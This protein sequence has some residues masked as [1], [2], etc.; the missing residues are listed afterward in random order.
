MTI[1]EF[2]HWRKVDLK[3]LLSSC[4]VRSKG[5][6]KYSKDILLSV[7][8][9]YEGQRCF[10]LGNGPSLTSEDLDKLKSEI[11]FASNRI[12]K[13]FHETEWRPTYFVMFDE[14][15]GMSEGVA[16]NISKI[17]CI[18][19]VREQGYFAYKDITG[20]VCFI[21]SR[22]NRKYLD[23]PQFSENLVCYI[24]S[25]STVT[26][27]AI[28][29]ARWMGFNEIYLLGMDNK[30]AY[31][32]LRDGSIVRN[33]GVASYFSDQGQELPAP[34]TAVATWEMDAAYEYAEKYSREHGFR[35]YNATRGGFLEK[36]E[37]VDLDEILARTEKRG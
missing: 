3:Y 31:S 37:R 8:G 36:F 15:V 11:T 35:I 5:L 21:H 12:Y 30:Y 16:K 23:N 13:I 18:K 33:E 29:I 34:T 2:A 14:G 27:A 28:Q 22:Y 24:Y 10:V 9:K 4:Q 20:K 26:Y 7:K 17:D 6:S 25:I 1:R 19:F 32:R